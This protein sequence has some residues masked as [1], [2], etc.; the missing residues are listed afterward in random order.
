MSAQIPDCSCPACSTGKKAEISAS[1]TCPA[2]ECPLNDIPDGVRTH[3]RELRGCRQLRSRLYSLGFTPGTEITVYGHN[4]AG[5]RVQ[6]R[7]TCV[8][9]DCESA[10]NILCGETRHPKTVSGLR[11]TPPL[12]GIFRRQGRKGETYD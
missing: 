10:D 3:V 4:D 7:D 9:L 1:E 2:D 12:Q 5:C 11:E 6:V 8:V